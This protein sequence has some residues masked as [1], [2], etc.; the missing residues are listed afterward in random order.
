MGLRRTILCATLALAAASLPACGTEPAEGLFK[1]V[2][3][4]RAARTL[5]SLQQGLITAQA[6]GAE[7]GS[8]SAAALAATL[9]QRDPSNRYT[10]A[11]PTDAGIVQVV[12]GAGGPLMLV[13]ISGPPGSGR[14]PSYLAVWQSGGSTLFYAGAAPPQYSSSPPAGPGWGSSPPQV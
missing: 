1:N 9:Q 12:G 3:K 7:S 14:A 10:T 11:P 8:T 5:S 4:A 13:G 2:D 6:T